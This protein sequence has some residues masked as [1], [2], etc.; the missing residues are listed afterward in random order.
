MGNDSGHTEV[1]SVTDQCVVTLLLQYSAQHETVRCQAPNGHT[2]PHSANVGL[3]WDYSGIAVV[4]GA[5]DVVLNILG[6][7]GP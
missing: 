3:I 2:G 4:T 7:R 1:V 5:F 6:K